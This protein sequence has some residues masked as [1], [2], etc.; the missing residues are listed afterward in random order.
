[1]T[2]QKVR[3][4]TEDWDDFKMLPEELPDYHITRRVSLGADSVEYAPRLRAY[5]TNDRGMAKISEL[6]DP[7]S[8]G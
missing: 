5:E 1:M 3:K 7:S 6:K 4:E 8:L 2:H